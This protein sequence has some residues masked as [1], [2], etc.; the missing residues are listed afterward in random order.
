LF[1]RRKDRET[2]RAE[3]DEVNALIA[4]HPLASDRVRAAHQVIDD[5]RS[6]GVEEVDE[7]LADHALPSVVELGRAQVAGFWSWWSLHRR[8]RKLSQRIDRADR[9]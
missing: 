1:G 5:S 3:L 8:R 7:A 4:A 2:L 9:R 6:R